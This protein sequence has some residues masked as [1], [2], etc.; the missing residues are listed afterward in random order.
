MWDKEKEKKE[1]MKQ[2]LLRMA[3]NGEPRP[4]APP[5]TWPPTDEDLDVEYPTPPA[6]SAH[7]FTWRHDW[8]LN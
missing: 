8:G 5:L 7:R 6:H 3:R 2:E 4:V 1:L